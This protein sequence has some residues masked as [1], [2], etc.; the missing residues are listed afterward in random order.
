MRLTYVNLT[1][2]TLVSNLD[3]LRGMPIDSIE[4]ANTSVADLS[5]LLGM[6]LNA[7][8]CGNTGVSDLSPLKGMPLTEL[9]IGDTLVSDLGPLEGMKL[10]LLQFTPQKIIRGMDIVRQMKNLNAINGQPASDFWRNL[11][12][13][14]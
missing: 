1:Q 2:A 12:T 14:Q 11:E 6:P 3:P 5:P 9:K 10:S 4:L 8:T 13:A 7:L